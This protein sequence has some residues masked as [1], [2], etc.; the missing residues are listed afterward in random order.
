MTY[1]RGGKRK[2]LRKAALSRR[3][4]RDSILE[5]I[6]QLFP[7]DFYDAVHL[8]PFVGSS[9]RL[10]GEA[11]ALTERPPSDSVSIGSNRYP[12]S[13]ADRLSIS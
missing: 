6:R 12:V 7:V 11:F 9:A 2:F 1:S 5:F 8:M 3:G 4:N 10:T 13:C